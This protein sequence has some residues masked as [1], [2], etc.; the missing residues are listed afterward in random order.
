MKIQCGVSPNIRDP[1]L[2]IQKQNL[3]CNFDKGIA[4][5]SVDKGAVKYYE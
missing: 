4:L 3:D 2:K 1:C 5:Y